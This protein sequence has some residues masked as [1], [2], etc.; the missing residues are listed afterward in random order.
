MF[1]ADNDSTQAIWERFKQSSLTC[2]CIL[3][4]GLESIFQ[5]FHPLLHRLVPDML[6][7][8]ADALIISKYTQA[9]WNWSR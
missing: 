1:F 2:E 3:T 4:K 9:S 5:S 8:H 6:R 7:S